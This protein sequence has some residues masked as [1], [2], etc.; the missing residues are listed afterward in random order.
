MPTLFLALL[1]ASSAAAGFVKGIVVDIKK[2]TVDVMDEA[3]KVVMLRVTDDLLAG[4]VRS[5]FAPDQFKQLAMGQQ[6]ALYTHTVK[7]KEICF[8]I[9]ILKPYVPPVG[10]PVKMSG[11]IPVRRLPRP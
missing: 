10:P 7:G 4:K 9:E 1:V 6:V 3:G 2:D 8:D 11:A 5:Q